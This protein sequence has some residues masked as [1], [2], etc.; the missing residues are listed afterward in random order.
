LLLG[1]SRQAYYQGK[2][3]QQKEAFQDELII[4]KVLS[5][6]VNQKR[7]GTRKLLGEMQQF[8]CAN[9]ITLGRDALFN[10][11]GERGLLVRKRKRRGPQTTF[12]RHRFKKYPNLIRE[13]IPTAPNQ[14]WVSDITYIHVG[15]KFAYLS[16]Q[17][18]RSQN[19]THLQTTQPN[20]TTKVCK[21]VWFTKRTRTMQTKHKSPSTE[22]RAACNSGFAK[23]RV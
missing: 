21:R 13:L 2:K 20:A 3:Y 4:S 19:H 16:G 6:R 14:L 23:K 8:L 10:L 1:N 22:R 18:I 12:S 17:R 7:I 11:L 5:Y 9:S 15:D